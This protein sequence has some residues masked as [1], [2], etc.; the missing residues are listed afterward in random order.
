MCINQFKMK[1]L[2]FFTWHMS[3]HVSKKDAVQI[4]SFLEQK[5]KLEKGEVVTGRYFTE[6]NFENYRIEYHNELARFEVEGNDL[7]VI[8]TL[9][10]LIKKIPAYVKMG[11]NRNPHEPD[12][13]LFFPQ[14]DTTIIEL[15]EGLKIEERWGFRPNIA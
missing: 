2:K 13:E 15:V 3:E 8:N 5:A 7:E 6:I 14:K 10:L 1:Q 11:I 9:M 12:E 4:F